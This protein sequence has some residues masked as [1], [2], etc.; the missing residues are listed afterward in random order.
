MMKVDSRYKCRGLRIRFHYALT[1]R[2]YEK[3]SIKCTLK[4][5]T[6]AVLVDNNYNP[7]ENQASGFNDKEYSKAKAGQTMMIAKEGNVQVMPKGHKSKDN[8][9]NT[10]IKNNSY[11]RILE[12]FEF[13]WLKDFYLEFFQNVNDPIMMQIDLF[14]IPSGS[15]EKRRPLGY[16]QLRINSDIDGKMV[17]GFHHLNILAYPKHEPSED[18]IGISVLDPTLYKHSLHGEDAYRPD[19]PVSV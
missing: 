4:T 10:L 16:C 5:S 15:K 18:F 1:N 3:F 2:N 19:T 6:G 13:V 17:Y 11:V 14:G 9:V 12:T 7:C 8:S